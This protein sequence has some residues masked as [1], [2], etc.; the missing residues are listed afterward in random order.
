MSPGSWTGRVDEFVGAGANRTA[1]DGAGPAAA[2]SGATDPGAVPQL[3]LVLASRIGVV[4]FRFPFG[5]TSTSAVPSSFSTTATLTCSAPETDSAIPTVRVLPSAVTPQPEQTR[6]EVIGSVGGAGNRMKGAAS[7][8]YL[9]CPGVRMSSWGSRPIRPHDIDQQAVVPRSK[10]ERERLPVDFGVSIAH[11]PAIDHQEAIDGR[12]AVGRAASAPVHSGSQGPL[13]VWTTLPPGRR[14]ASIW[15]IAA[16]INR[17]PLW[18]GVSTA[19][20][21][22][23]GAGSPG[24]PKS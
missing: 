19:G 23:V 13:Q 10:P 5:S 14:K 3:D 20:G 6:F 16:G 4:S 24:T 11:R 21:V 15:A 9:G 7:S 18:G 17:R 1:R 2:R 8:R 12:V 22:G